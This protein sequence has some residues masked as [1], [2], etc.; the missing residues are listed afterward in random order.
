[1]T[2]TT[3][4]TQTILFQVERLLLVRMLSMAFKCEPRL[5]EG[6]MIMQSLDD[7]ATS[8]YRIQSVSSNEAVVAWR[9]ALGRRICMC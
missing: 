1:M 2:K 8:T 5:L 7:L 3:I 4:R 6:H 9:M